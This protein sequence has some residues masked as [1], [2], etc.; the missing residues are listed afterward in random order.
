MKEKNAVA[1]NESGT[2]RMK[3][4]VRHFA[5]S[6]HCETISQIMRY[7]S[8]ADKSAARRRDFATVSI[9]LRIEVSEVE[10]HLLYLRN[11]LVEPDEVG[12]SRNGF[13]R[14]CSPPTSQPPIA[15]TI[16]T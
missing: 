8:P 5:F 9:F 15:S 14:S 12:L 16:S 10:V 3:R 13:G 1:L 6:A 4:K 7:S 11:F 2:G